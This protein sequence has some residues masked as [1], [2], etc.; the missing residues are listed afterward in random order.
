MALVVVGAWQARRLRQAVKA[1]ESAVAETRRIG[2]AQVRAY[3]GIKTAVL[4]F[5]DNWVPG[6]AHPRLTIIATNSG[7]SPARKFIWKP[8]IEYIGGDQR[9]QRGLNGNWVAPPGASIPVG[10]PFQESVLIPDMSITRFA[11][12]VRPQDHILVRIR[13]EFT[14]IDVFD[15]RFDD[16]VFF[17]GI[18]AP[19]KETSRPNMWAVNLTPEANLR[20]WDKPGPFENQ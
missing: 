11:A 18:A 1:T 10:D 12:S 6:E 5:L 9:R 16:Q 15:R 4:D 3:V 8:T 2:E 17:V 19:S 13:V 14:F 20:D 7:Q